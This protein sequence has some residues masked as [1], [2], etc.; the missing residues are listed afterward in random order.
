MKKWRK[1]QCHLSKEA[2]LSSDK[3]LLDQEG[4][5]GDVG[6]VHFCKVELFGGGTHF[7]AVRASQE[8]LAQN[9]GKAGV[10]VHRNHLL[11]WDRLLHHQ[12]TSFI[13]HPLYINKLIEI[14][15]YFDWFKVG[16][17]PLKKI[18]DKRK[19]WKVLKSVGKEFPESDCEIHLVW[20][21]VKQ[22]KQKMAQNLFMFSEERND[23]NF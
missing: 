4:G 23:Y 10:A 13:S 12:P 9:V 21:N 5:S 17:I 18:E 15:F 8:V 3:V 14:E 1:C 22:R 19:R 20:Q 11:W 2:F 6:M 7:E 16:L